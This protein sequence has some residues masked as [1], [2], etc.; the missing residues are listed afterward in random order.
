MG[1]G[2]LNGGKHNPPAE[3]LGDRLAINTTNNLA[4]GFTQGP[5]HVSH[6]HGLLAVLGST[7]SFFPPSGRHQLL[8]ILFISCRSVIIVIS[9]YF[10]YLFI[11]E[12]IL[13]ICARLY[14]VEHWG[15]ALCNL[16]HVYC[17]TF[18]LSVDY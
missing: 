9:H 11:V 4:L 7:S 10:T 14:A 12:F 6:S 5:V 8:Y 18:L 17:F 2:D 1:K 13:D 16:F 15:F 3:L